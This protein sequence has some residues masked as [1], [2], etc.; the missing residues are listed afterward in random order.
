MSRSEKKIAGFK[1]RNDRTRKRM[2]HK[3]ARQTEDLPSGSYYKYLVNPL[4]ICD[5]KW[6][7]HSY[8][9][10]WQYIQGEGVENFYKVWRK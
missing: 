9:D 8:K 4:H 2:V 10:M 5:W 6:L 1:Q 3:K 7:Y